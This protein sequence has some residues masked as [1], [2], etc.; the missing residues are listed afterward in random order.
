M[1][2]STSLNIKLKNPTDIY[3]VINTLTNIQDSFRIS[4]TTSATQ[5]NCSR[6]TT[7]EIRELIS[8]KRRARNTWQRTH[9]PIDKQRYNYFSNKLKSTLKKHKNQLYTSHIQSLSPSNGSLWRKTKAL[10]KHKST[11]PPLR[12]Q[13]NNLATTD[14]DKSDQLANHLANT[15][16]PHN[17]SPDD[18]HM[19][20]VDQ[21]I[22]SPLP[23]ALP[24]SPTTPGEV[25]SI[26]K[27]LR[28]NKSPGHDLINNKIVKNLP[29]KTIILLTYIFNA[30]F[31][32]SYF[33]TT[34]KSALIITILKPG[35]QPDLP[36][37]YRP[38]S[39]LPTFEKFLKNFFSKDL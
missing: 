23:M 8:Q 27:K 24:A 10:L 3:T 1:S 7:P 9:Y 6:N 34:R 22:S 32:L 35:K 31:R 2:T 15:F 16:K 11:I 26:V 17:I 38:I 39:L 14:Q 36:E 12:Y 30:I 37:S 28:N 25:L 5:D 4:S 21:F 29:P 19:L 13:N 33:P 20:Q 18:T